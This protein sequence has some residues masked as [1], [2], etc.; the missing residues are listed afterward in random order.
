M[1]NN[2]SFLNGVSGVASIASASSVESTQWTK[3]NAHQAHGFTSEDYNALIDIL[4][5]KSVDKVGLNNELNGADRIANGVK[6]QSK[7]GRTAYD[8]IC[9]AFD[10]N[11]MFRYPDMVIEVPK[12]QGNDAIRIMEER[13]RNGQV[14]GVT[15][16][17]MAKTM[18][19]EGHCTYKQAVKIAK[20]G[21]LESIKFDAMNQMV[22]CTCIA[23][24]TFVI[25][26]A[27]SRLSGISKE[28]ALRQSV[29]QAIKTGATTLAAGV[30]VQQ[31][32]RTQVGRNMAACATNMARKG[33]NA[34]CRT[35]VG[36]A[37]V[38]KLMTGIMG[39]AATQA[40]A[41]NACVKL[42]RSNFFTSAAITVATTVPDVVKA[43]R[44]KKS[45]KQ[46]GKNAVVNVTGIG[47]GSAGWWA[48][49]A[50][51]S[52]VCP[53]VGT[54]VGGLIGAIGGG[55]AGSFGAKTAMDH[56]VEDDSKLCAKYVQDAII[57]LCEE[58]HVSED[59]L[60]GI[61]KKIHSHNVFKESFFEKMYRAGGKNRDCDV[62]RAFAVKELH[63]FFG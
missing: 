22:T 17:A 19:T 16:P 53:G 8:S 60:S 46:V 33:V 20:A 12:G 25:G 26:Y 36:K 30:A 7:Y 52:F 14:P 39:K 32:L 2:S 56:F 34:V 63:P 31:I 44:G 4:C 6:I 15:D 43:C 11:G 37:T 45:W 9:G 28:A 62:M 59:A 51:G 50:A 24:L 23:G 49:A 27:T 61:I 54:I 35:Q 18:V 38:E 13:I 21:N 55:V 40:S 41:K 1:S 57:E 48:G 29:E 42:M 47:T 5:G 3:Y 10:K 58:N